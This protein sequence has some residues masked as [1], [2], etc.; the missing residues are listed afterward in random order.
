MREKRQLTDAQS[1][2]LHR[3]YRPSRP[4]EPL[5]F[6]E[7]LRLREYAPLSV[8]P[9]GSLMI[10]GK[11]HS[12]Y[13]PRTGLQKVDNYLGFQNALLNNTNNDPR[14][15]PPPGNEQT[16]ERAHQYG[17]ELEGARP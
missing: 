6:V 7:T 10:S 1:R 13:T 14:P 8:E 11:G 12:L 2:E 3:L 17:T 5:L 9:A 15:K 16:K 4:D